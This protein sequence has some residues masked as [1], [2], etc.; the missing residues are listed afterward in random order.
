MDAIDDNNTHESKILIHNGANTYLTLN[1][2]KNGIKFS[3]KYQNI[4]FAYPAKSNIKIA[5]PENDNV[6][7]NHLG[8]THVY[9]AQTPQ[10]TTYTILDKCYTRA[11]NENIEFSDESSLLDYCGYKSHIYECSPSNNKITF[12]SDLPY[13]YRFGQGEDS[14]AFLSQYDDRKPLILGSIKFDDKLSIDANSDGDVIIHALINSLQGILGLKPLGSFADKMYSDG[15]E[16]SIDY[17]A[18]PLREIHKNKY[19]IEY[20]SVHIEAKFPRILPYH[21]KLIDALSE[22]LSIGTDKI[23]LTYETG[24]ELSE[25]AKGNGIR[26][27][28]IIL[29]KKLYTYED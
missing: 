15:I 12:T 27:K 28:S 13:S 18:V 17:I 29:A 10:I 5:D 9:E 3:K 1:E 19:E 22:I 4:V 7:L 26:V 20:V 23:A 14:H 24:D 6:I 11:A 2:L 21:D 16:S 25:F 8:K